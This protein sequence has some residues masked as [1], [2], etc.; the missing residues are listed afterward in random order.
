VP[1][2]GEERTF[3]ARLPKLA[4]ATR[5]VFSTATIECYSARVANKASLCRAPISSFSDDGD[6][7]KNNE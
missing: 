2:T 1:S 3:S 7:E 6:D 4:E 5:V